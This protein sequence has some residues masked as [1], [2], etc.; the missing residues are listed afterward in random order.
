MTTST[1]MLPDDVRPLI[2]NSDKYMGID[3]YDFLKIQIGVYAVH[4]DKGVRH[5]PIT[6]KVDQFN[7]FGVVETEELSKWHCWGNIRQQ[8]D[9][10][11]LTWLMNHL[12]DEKAWGHGDY[13]WFCLIMNLLDFGTNITFPDIA[14]LFNNTYNFTLYEE[15]DD[16]TGCVYKIDPDDETM[17][18]FAV[19]KSSCNEMADKLM[20]QILIYED[21]L[22]ARDCSYSFKFIDADETPIDKQDEMN[23]SINNVISSE[24]P[25]RRLL[26]KKSPFG[27]PKNWSMLVRKIELFRYD[28]YDVGNVD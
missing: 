22:G 8:M 17:L 27:K 13:H 5:Y 9:T 20:E 16:K 23:Q 3:F 15:T 19:P 14:P 25:K 21:L 11:D 1:W 6:I 10:L 12:G 26:Y 2:F 28:V 18:Y 7:N 24:L 4:D